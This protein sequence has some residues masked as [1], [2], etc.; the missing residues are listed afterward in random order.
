MYCTTCACTVEGRSH[1][2]SW[3]RRVVS[4]GQAGRWL[5]GQNCQESS[6]VVVA[7]P[8]ESFQEPGTAGTPSHRA[9]SSLHQEGRPHQRLVYSALHST[10]HSAVHTPKSTLLPFTLLKS[11]SCLSDDWIVQTAALPAALTDRLRT[12][13]RRRTTE[14]FGNYYGTSKADIETK[15]E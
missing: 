2:N 8:S 5:W 6:A 3:P 12:R 1:P 7:C 9:Q 15:P 11:V 10:L 4:T 14:P 13:R